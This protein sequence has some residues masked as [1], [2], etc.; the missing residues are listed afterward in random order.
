[1]I[2]GIEGQQAPSWQGVTWF[3]LPSGRTSLD[4]GDLRGKVIY[5]Y[6]FQSWCPGCHAH[7]FPLLE[8]TMANFK[9]N[10]DVSFVTIQTVFEGFDTNTLEEAKKVVSQNNLSIPA[11]HDSGVQNLGSQVMQ[12]YRSGGTPWTIVIDKEG[13]VRYNHF[14]AGS[15]AM[16]EFI[17]NLRARKNS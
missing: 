10:D 5:L 17:E 11:G 8:S 15:K 2:Y 3:N 1:M 9:D 6:C 4:V 14:Q 16:I 7:G 13:V 12:R